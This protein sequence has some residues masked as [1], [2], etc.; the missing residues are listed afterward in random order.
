[1]EWS[2]EISGIVIQTGEIRF[3]LP[4]PG[5][6]PPPE[7][8]DLPDVRL[9]PDAAEEA[10]EKARRLEWDAVGPADLPEIE[11][12]LKL[13]AASGHADAMAKLGLIAEGRTR[14]QLAGELADR[15]TPAQVEAAERWYRR[16]AQHGSGFGALHL[17]RI[18]EEEHG[19]ATQAL[20]WYEK[21]A[22]RGFGVARERYDGLRKRLSLGLGALA[23]RKPMSIAHPAFVQWIQDE[24]EGNEALATAFCLGALAEA[25]GGPYGEWGTLSQD[26]Q[27]LLLQHFSALHP[28]K[29]TLPAV[30][31]EY[32]EGIGDGNLRRVAARIAADPLLPANEFA[33][34]WWQRKLEGK[35]SRQEF[36]YHVELTIED[37]DQWHALLVQLIEDLGRNER[38]RANVLDLKLICNELAA[39]RSTSL[40]AL[41]GHDLRE[42]FL[43]LTPEQWDLLLRI[44]DICMNDQ[45]APE[46]FREFWRGIDATLRA[47]PT[48]PFE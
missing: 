33:P 30:A 27:I 47:A 31:F 8:H 7:P 38:H 42:F 23:G 41:G 11:H 36:V 37:Y 48:E 6:P 39:R 18:E 1:M 40:P 3:E 13:A 9:D 44:G 19:N 2:S 28:T 45:G 4:S 16:S 20:S 15:P 12:L 17:G 32:Q 5:A 29:I 46:D 25:C 26:E 22:N 21:A 10:Y 35:I 43:V 34:V 14:A 24:W